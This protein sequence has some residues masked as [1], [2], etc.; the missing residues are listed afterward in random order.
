MKLKY[1]AFFIVAIIF[2]RDISYA[3]GAHCVPTTPLTEDSYPFTAG[4]SLTMIFHYRWGVINADLGKGSVLLDTSVLN[5]IPVFHC[6]AS[7]RTYKFYDNFFEVRENFQSWF[8]KD[9]L[10]PMRFT[11]NTHEGDYICRNDFSYKWTPGNEHIDANLY[12][13]KKGARTITLPLSKCVFDL[14]ALYYMARNMDLS[15]VAK[16]VKYPMTFVIDDD[17]YN[18]YFIFRGREVKEVEGLGNIHTLRFSAQLLK[19]E[20]FKGDGDM[21]LWITDDDNR[22]PV[23]IEAPIRVGFISARVT[24]YSGLKHPFKSLV[25]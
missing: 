25:K 24:G 21:T 10:V 9:G 7:G 20:V 8:T 23:Y 12:T 18:V 6:K 22:I 17:V 13:L 14:P 2:T 3:Q 4:E 15:K 16:D 19:G 1:I 5:G 11:R